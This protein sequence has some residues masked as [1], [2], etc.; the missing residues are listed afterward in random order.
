MLIDLYFPTSNLF[1]LTHFFP[2]PK[3]LRKVLPGE[4]DW[5][6]GA[7]VMEKMKAGEQRKRKG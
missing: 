2:F 3:T 7:I 1:R 4:T 5:G 6:G